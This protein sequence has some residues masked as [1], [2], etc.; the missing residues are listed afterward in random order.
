M[1]KQYAN[2]DIS[3]VDITI[4]YHQRNVHIW[5]CLRANPAKITI[6]LEHYSLAKI[7]DIETWL[8]NRW[9]EKDKLLSGH[10]CD[11]V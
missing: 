10:K 8:N 6:T 11:A 3:L 1:I 4:D 7:D 5:N 9:L 2:A